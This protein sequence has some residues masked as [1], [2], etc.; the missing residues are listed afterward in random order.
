MTAVTS[1]VSISVCRDLAVLL[2]CDHFFFLMEG[3]VQLIATAV[4]T[5]CD[6]H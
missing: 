2:Q 5:Q 3:E 1:I 6:S 4:W